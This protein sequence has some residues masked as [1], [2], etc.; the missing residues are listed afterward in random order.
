[1]GINAGIDMIMDPYDP[2]CCNVIVD[3]VKSGDIPMARLDDAVRRV[4]RLKVR[5]GLFENP[6]WEHEYPEFASE[7]FAKQSYAAAVESEVLLK[8]EGILPLKGNER[9]LVTGPNANSL[10]T[11]NG[12][13]SYTWQG[14]A[15]AFAPQ[16]NTILEAIQKRF[17]NV[18]Y[19]PGVEYDNAFGS[20]QSE[21]VVSG[22]LFS[23]IEVAARRADVIIACVGENSYCETPGNMNDLNLSENQKELVRKLASSGKPVILVL[24]EGRPRI[25][26]DIEPLAKAVVDVM[27]PSN[28][29][30]DA[31]AALLA[32]DE[33]FSGKLPFTY[34][35]Y[36]NS[37]HTYDYKVSEHREVMDGAYNY[38][39]VMDVQ[40]AF[41]Y[42]LSY[43][44][45]AYS[46][47]VLES[48]ADFKA[49]DDLKVSVKVTNTGDRAGKEAVLLYSSDLVA[50]LIQGHQHRRPRRQGGRP[51]VQLRPRSLPHS[52]RQAPP[53]LRKDFAGTGR[54]QDRLLRDPGPRARL[55]GR[56]RQ[57]APGSGR[58]PSLLRRPRRDGQVHG[59]QGLGHPEHLGP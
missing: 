6:T 18:T 24:N 33:N 11:L 20:W 29:G 36:I 52:G 40:W 31:L 9:I 23:S 54:N 8:N 42:G 2:E 47:L 49:G 17:K 19:V 3:L 32:G 56:R 50:S 7:E 45:F 21:R 30:G 22:S 51:A 57:V 53:R 44:S 59:N 15:D 39:A 34:P 43:T 1:M 14:N 46:D 28:Y 48:P 55:R 10:R 5:L 58:L 27:L 41:G 25:I 13:W 37:L 35:K 26:G 4:L 38:D 16:Y 12:G